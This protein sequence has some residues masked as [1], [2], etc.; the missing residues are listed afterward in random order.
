MWFL[1]KDF[2]R[3]L[4]TGNAMQHFL[5]TTVMTTAKTVPKIIGVQLEDYRPI[6]TCRLDKRAFAC[7]NIQQV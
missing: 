1:R 2:F 3:I 5:V 6:M 4:T 7:L